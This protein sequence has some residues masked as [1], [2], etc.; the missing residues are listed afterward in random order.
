MN[1]QL[2]YY[3][4]NKGEAY[5]HSL[6]VDGLSLSGNPSPTKKL[7]NTPSPSLMNNL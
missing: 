5:N 3:L 2:Y 4:K 1:Q 7:S 6:D